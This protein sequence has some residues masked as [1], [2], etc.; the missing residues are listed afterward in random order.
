MSNNIETKA[1]NTFVFS[2]KL[3][4]WKLSERKLQAVAER[5]GIQDALDKTKMSGIITKSQYETIRAT[6]E[7]NRSAEQVEQL[8][9][10]GDNDE[11][12]QEFIMGLVGKSKDTNIILQKLDE[13]KTVDHPNGI[14]ITVVEEL[15]GD[16]Q[17]NEEVAYDIVVSR[18]EKVPYK[19][20]KQYKDDT[21]KIIAKSNTVIKIENKE[22]LKI[23]RKAVAASDVEDRRQIVTDILEEQSKT[24]PSYKDVM[25]RIENIDD[26]TNMGDDDTEKKDKREKEV[27]LTA[28]GDR[29][30][31]GYRNYKERKHTGYQPK[32]QG[33]ESGGNN[34]PR[35]QG[36]NNGNGGGR[37]QKNFGKCP[38]CQVTRQKDALTTP[39]ING[40][41]TDS[42]I[43]I[44]TGILKPE[45]QA[46][47]QEKGLS[48]ILVDY[49]IGTETKTQE[50]TAPHPEEEETDKEKEAEAEHPEEKM[51]NNNNN[52][53]LTTHYYQEFMVDG[54]NRYILEVRKIGQDAVRHEGCGLDCTIWYNDVPLKDLEENK[55]FLKYVK[56]QRKNMGDNEFLNT[57][58]GIHYAQY[59]VASPKT[60]W[61]EWKEYFS[62]LIAYNDSMK[63]QLRLDETMNDDEWIKWHAVNKK[64]QLEKRE[65][66]G[67]NTEYSGYNAD[68]SSTE[69]DDS[70]TTM[71]ELIKR[72]DYSSS[73]EESSRMGIPDLEPRDDSTA[74]S[75]DSMIGENVTVIHGQEENVSDLEHQM[76]YS[77]MWD[78]RPVGSLQDPEVQRDLA[79][80]NG[81]DPSVEVMTDNQRVQEANR[82]NEEMADT[83][84]EGTRVGIEIAVPRCDN[85]GLFQ[86]RRRREYG[87][88]DERSAETLVADGQQAS[89]TYQRAI[90]M[91]ASSARQYRI[92]ESEDGETIYLWPAD[93]SDDEDFH[94]AR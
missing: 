75:K 2:G 64:H 9:L 11:I 26:L 34:Y 1:E 29:R 71:P 54:E 12:I 40:S 27:Q 89:T 78:K 21:E 37:G 22:R 52:I 14:L 55:E 6:E 19:N 25:R 69:S 24:N 81:S 70:S 58:D 65:S 39:Q 20:S 66:K 91:G 44:D 62:Y 57:P 45:D 80:V 67:Y 51:E 56:E 43:P 82:A 46:K 23:L 84:V 86:S 36:R 32:R 31:G 68:D 42:R 49:G 48:D 59:K 79:S 61:Y 50:E 15:N 5:L 3:D 60:I 77:D 63:R 8:E 35:L 33:G 17:T 28:A 83:I 41:R 30:N 90:V 72:D 76:K 74:S 85:V 93:T 47:E 18:M 16:I 38:H 10:Y 87:F 94:H 53:D 7:A 4:D 73:S 88:H 92:E 13:T